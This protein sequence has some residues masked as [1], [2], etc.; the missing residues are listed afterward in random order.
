MFGEQD[1]A[2]IEG[3]VCE[4]GRLE[5]GEIALSCLSRCVGHDRVPPVNVGEERAAVPS[6][7]EQHQHARDVQDGPDLAATAEG[8]ET[9]FLP[10][11]CGGEPEL[12]A[13]RCP[14]SAPK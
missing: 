9:G 4:L 10:R 11:T 12:L 13:V 7:V 1:P 14:C 8:V 5:P 2:P 3:E 6:D